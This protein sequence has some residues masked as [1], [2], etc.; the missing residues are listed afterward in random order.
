MPGSN[1]SIQKLVQNSDPLRWVF[2]GDSITHGALHTMGWRD[3]V[4]LFGERVRWEMGRV[5]DCVI[6]T[7][8][9]GWRITD[10][11][12]DFEWS[13]AQHRPHVVSINV[14]MND[15][16]LQEAGLEDFKKAYRQVIGKIREK[17]NPPIL[18]HTPTSVFPAEERRAPFLPAYVKA[19]RELAK[20]T[21][22]LLIDN[23]AD[24]EVFVQNQ[25]VPYLLSDAFHPN[26]C[27]HRLMHRTL[28]QALGMWDPNS[29]TGRLF[30]PSPPGAK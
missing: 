5:H 1:E 15:C 20:E 14:G 11:L 22:C 8:I 12:N 10:I 2:A 4:E 13:I 17:S 18:L 9:S 6:K 30:I 21:D 29:N 16:T 23:F 27:G 19:I 3:Y 7:A 24:W 28:L 25:W 26:E